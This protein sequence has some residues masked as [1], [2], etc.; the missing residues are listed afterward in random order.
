MKICKRT[1]S[2]ESYSSKISPLSKAKQAIK[3]KRFSKENYSRFK[4]TKLLY[5]EATEWKYKYTRQ[6]IKC[7][8]CHGQPLDFDPVDLSDD[9]EKIDKDRYF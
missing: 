4:F 9:E 6:I 8:S 1:E 2:S 5:R 3:N 7:L